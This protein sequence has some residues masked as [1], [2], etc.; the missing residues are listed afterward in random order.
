M[1]A[2]KQTKASYLP[3]AAIFSTMSFKSVQSAI[4]K[5]LRDELVVAADHD[6]DLEPLCITATFDGSCHGKLRERDDSSASPAWLPSWTTNDPVWSALCAN[7]EYWF[8]AAA[9]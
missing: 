4:E 7:S 6:T 5:F 1:T 8:P 9:P 3:L 2:T